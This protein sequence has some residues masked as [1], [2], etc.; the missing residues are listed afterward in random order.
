[1]PPIAIVARFNGPV[2]KAV[3]HL[4]GSYRYRVEKNIPV[5]P[6]IGAGGRSG[7][8]AKMQ[9]PWPLMRVGDS[10]MIPAAD[11]PAIAGASVAI[12]Q[13]IV[14]RKRN[15]EGEDYTYRTRRLDLHGEEGWRIWRTA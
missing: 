4:P 12:A 9:I 15:H 11:W 13:A 5:P 10:V 2:P 3:A 8:I 7:V 14:T 6:V 1:M